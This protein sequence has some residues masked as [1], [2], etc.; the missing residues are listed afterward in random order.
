MELDSKK[1]TLTISITLTL[2]EWSEVVKHGDE[3]I[4]P[5]YEI[6]AHVQ[7]VLGDLK[8]TLK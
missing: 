2:G 1:P 8:Q 3:K 4:Y 5:M 6:Y 7:K